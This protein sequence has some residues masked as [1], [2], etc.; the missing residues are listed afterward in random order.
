LIV[1]SPILHLVCQIG[2]L[3]DVQNDAYGRFPYGLPPKGQG[4]LAFVQHMISSLNAEGVCGVVM[5]HGV[6]F[7][8]S[9]E[10]EIRQGILE[11]DLLK[12]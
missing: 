11:A 10:K 5:P 12:R 9:K 2:D 4:D 1:S 7:R 8:G 6:L 3:D